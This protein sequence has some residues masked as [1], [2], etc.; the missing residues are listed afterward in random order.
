MTNAFTLATDLLA[1]LQTALLAGPNPPPEDKI[2]I[3]AGSEVTPLLGTLTDECC[4]GLGWV[5]I[6]SISGARDLNDS[7]LGCFGSERILTLEL[8][9]AR[10]APSPTLQAPPTEDQWL[11]S[12]AQL[13][14]D[15]GAMEEAICCAFGPETD[16]L[17]NARA[18]GEYLPFG[19]D[20]NC[21]G[22]TMTVLLNYDACCTGS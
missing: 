15:Q 16:F 11:A 14:A 5:R 1:C 3:R 17:Y 20:G 22:G 19:V 21:I 18:V 9:V 4:T 2:M 12:A 8:G 10:C 7:L 6:A 13:D